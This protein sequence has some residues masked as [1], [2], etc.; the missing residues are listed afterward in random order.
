MKTIDWVVIGI[1]LL[2]GVTLDPTDALDFGLPIF[3]GVGAIGYYIWRKD[4]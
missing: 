4:K 2:L 1:F 3:E